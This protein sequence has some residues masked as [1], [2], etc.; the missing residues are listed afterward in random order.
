VNGTRPVCYAVG[1][2]H[3]QSGEPGITVDD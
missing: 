3:P 2:P 1:K